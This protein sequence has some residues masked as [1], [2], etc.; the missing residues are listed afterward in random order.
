M[1][2]YLVEC[3]AVN[4][5]WYLQEKIVK[6]KDNQTRRDH[7]RVLKYAYNFC[8]ADANVAFLPEGTGSGVKMPDLRVDV[9]QASFYMEVKHFRMTLDDGNNPVLKIVATVTGKRSQLPPS[10]L[11]LIAMD[12]FDL[13][14]ENHDELGLSHEHI[15]QAICELKRMAAENPAGWEMPSG[16]VFAA[17][18]SGGSVSLVQ[19][20]PAPPMFP[21]FVW[22]NEQSVPSIPAGTVE[23]LARALPDGTIFDSDV[24][25]QE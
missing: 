24:A 13:G 21:H 3:G 22:A 17:C 5:Q 1:L 2:D 11:G 15:V 10:E 14:L 18:T 20:L 16:V 19:G 6:V 25:C 12:N 8:L 7:E 4:L 23:W 9:E